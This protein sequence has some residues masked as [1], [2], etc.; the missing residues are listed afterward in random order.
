M[1]LVGFIIRN[2]HDARSPERQK[3]IITF[4]MSANIANSVYG[5]VPCGPL[6]KNKSNSYNNNN[7]NNNNNSVLNSHTSCPKSQFRNVGNLLPINAA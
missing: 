4:N 2:C 6:N 1:H 3:C 5:Y 7:N